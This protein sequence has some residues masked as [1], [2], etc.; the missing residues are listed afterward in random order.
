[1]TETGKNHHLYMDNF[2]TEPHFFLELS[3]KKII[4]C[5]TVHQNR[6]VF[7]RDLIITTQMQK[8]MD[9]GNYLWRANIFSLC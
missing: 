1:M 2:Y 3:D 5:G 6:K 7:P 9:R 8:Q 4:V